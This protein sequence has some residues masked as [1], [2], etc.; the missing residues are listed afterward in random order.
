MFLSSSCLVFRFS[1]TLLYKHQNCVIAISKLKA[2][3]VYRQSQV[4]VYHTVYFKQAVPIKVSFNKQFYFIYAS[5][6]ICLFS[7]NYFVHGG[8][9]V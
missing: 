2:Q 4:S 6:L 9:L 3:I 1:K 8:S 5:S 7:I